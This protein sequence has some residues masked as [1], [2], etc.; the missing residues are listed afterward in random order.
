MKLM[1]YMLVINSYFISQMLVINL[2]FI[3]LKLFTITISI[4]LMITGAI[5]IPIL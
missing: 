1:S 2:D 5:S 3:T 4:A